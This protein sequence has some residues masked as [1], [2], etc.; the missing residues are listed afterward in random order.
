VRLLAD[1]AFSRGVVGTGSLGSGLVLHVG[2]ALSLSIQGILEFALA[3]ARDDVSLAH[4]L[5]F[6]LIGLC[7]HLVDD[8][9]GPG[10]THCLGFHVGA[11]TR[12]LLLTPEPESLVLEIVTDA[13]ET[14]T[15]NL[16]VILGLRNGNDLLMRHCEPFCL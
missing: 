16:E 11:S 3:G 10:D 4:V 2:N 15:E 5:S 7:E 1:G 13:I 12:E 8:L 14:L 6:V 9:D